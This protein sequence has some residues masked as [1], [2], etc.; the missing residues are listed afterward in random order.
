VP[1]ATAAVTL[2]LAD[3]CSTA[4]VAL[5]GTGGTG[6]GGGAGGTGGGG[7]AGGGGMAGRG[8]GT[9]GSGGGR[10]GAGGS[11]GTGRGGAGGAAPACMPGGTCTPAASEPCAVY[12]IDCSTG[13]PVC[14]RSGARPAGT[15][16]PTGVCSQGGTCVACTA[17]TDC[18]P[19]G[20]PC[21]VGT[22]AC[23]TGTPTCTAG[24]TSRADGTACGMDQVC[25]AGACVPCAANQSCTPPAGACV[26]GITSCTSG[27][28]VC[29]PTTPVRGGQSCGSNMVC[30]GGGVCVG[31]QQAAACTP[32]NSC[33][34][35]SL[36]CMT[37]L[38]LCMESA[39][40]LPDGLICGTD[41]LCAAGT[42]ASAGNWISRGEDARTATGGYIYSYQFGNGTVSPVTTSTMPY[43]PSPGGLTGN[44]LAISGTV[45]PEDPNANL[46]NGGGITLALTPN[47]TGMNVAARGS[48]ITL[49]A[50]SAQAITLQ[51][52]AVDI[53][54][55]D[56]HPN[57]ST[58]TAPTVVHRCFQNAQKNIAV[59]GGNVWTRFSFVWSDFRRP[60]WGNL[61]DNLPLDSSAM[62]E[63]HVQTPGVPM[64]SAA[65][66]YSF[67]VDDV[68]FVP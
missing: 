1:L 48:G 66:S 56:A 49:Y 3:V 52:L 23:A 8:G 54:T 5:V 57:C 51:I 37:G 22:L 35:G 40:T 38:P 12:T 27:T 60:L 64:G 11:G 2:V 46:F 47:N 62:L 44:A 15:A 61:G 67:A 30:N 14:Q 36:D 6:G 25:R 9:A 18:T 65:L 7:V 53:W 29:Q 63:L 16:C 50:K 55:S 10:G 31:C 68:A 26:N 28:S 13:A 4:T 19:T 58:S 34:T 17:G 39:Q 42:C 59:P 41:R 20:A 21:R 24:T 43:V 32:N 33:R 45:P